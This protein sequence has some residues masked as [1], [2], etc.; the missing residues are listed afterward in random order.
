MSR[1]IRA[2]TLLPAI[3]LILLVDERV[4]HAGD[5]IA[6][7]AGQRLLGGFFAVVTRQIVGFLHP[8]GEELSGDALGVFFLCRQRRAVVKIFVEKVFQT[9]A[10]GFDRRAEGG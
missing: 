10:L 3:L 4:G 8:V 5:V 1:I 9:T 6:D 7:D 2:R